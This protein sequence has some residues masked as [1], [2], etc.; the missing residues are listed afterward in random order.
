VLSGSSDSTI[1]LWS[2]KTSRCLAT[3]ETHADSVWTLYSDHPQLKTFFAGSKDG[4]V[5]RTELGSS[6]AGGPSGEDECVG[7]FKENEGVAKI[8]VLDD[9]YIWTATSSSSVNRWVSQ[10]AC[11]VLY[12]ECLLT[13]VV[14]VEYTPETISRIAISISIQP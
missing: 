1:K 12:V 5:T 7:I 14:I 9:T 11:M 3:Y 13:L 10:W 4:L 2:T 6:E 8:V